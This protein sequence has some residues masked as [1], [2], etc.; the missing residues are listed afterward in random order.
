MP[1]RLAD[2]VFDLLL[3]VRVPLAVFL[4]IPNSP[5]RHRIP[6]AHGDGPRHTRLPSP[7]QPALS[8][9]GRY[10]LGNHTATL[11]DGVPADG[12]N[13]HADAEEARW[14]CHPVGSAA[15]ES[16]GHGWRE[17]TSHSYAHPSLWQVRLI[18][19]SQSRAQTANRLRMSSSPQLG[20][21]SRQSDGRGRVMHGH[22]NSHAGHPLRPTHCRVAAY[23]KRGGA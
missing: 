13:G 11:R 4:P 6:A 9:Q 20:P 14:H 12:L 5:A 3:L 23:H 15:H 16:H 18:A 10:S 19:P 8:I 21:S 17:P 1:G 7:E 22:E 2:L